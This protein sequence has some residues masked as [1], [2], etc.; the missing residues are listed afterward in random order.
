MQVTVAN[1]AAQG[2]GSFPT[3]ARR[4]DDLATCVQQR[5]VH[6]QFERPSVESFHQREEIIAL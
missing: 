6:K 3:G 4:E 5:V 1:A 2:P